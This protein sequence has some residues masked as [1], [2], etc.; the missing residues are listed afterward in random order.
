MQ[1]GSLNLQCFNEPDRRK[2]KMVCVCVC[3]YIYIY[4][5]GMGPDS[6]DGIAIRYG[7]DGQGIESQ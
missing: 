6:S 2:S 4:K 1:L 5:A 7:L 3:V